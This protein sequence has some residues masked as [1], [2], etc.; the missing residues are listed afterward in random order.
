MTFT[1][2]RSFFIIKDKGQ[3]NE[4]KSRHYLRNQRFKGTE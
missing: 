4:T 1:L 3:I 2:L